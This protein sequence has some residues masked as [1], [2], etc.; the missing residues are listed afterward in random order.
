MKTFARID[1]GRVAEIILPMSYDVDAP[2][3]P[4]PEN[5]PDGWPTFKAG[6][7]VPIDKRFTADLVAT[8]VDITNVPGVSVGD[9]YADGVFAPY[10]PPAR[11]PFEILATN[12]A[13]R[14]ALLALAATRIA[15]LQDA[16]DLDMAT[17]EERAQLLAWKQ[18]RVAVNRVVLS[19]TS[20]AWPVPPT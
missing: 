4:D 13:H 14:D 6:D 10:V 2:L 1:T 8:L 11:S 5:P 17:D 9:T 18:Y 20:P 15:P 7:E 16:V 19:V 3:P 12:E